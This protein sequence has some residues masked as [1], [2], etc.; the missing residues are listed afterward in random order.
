MAG[1]KIQQR[2]FDIIYRAIRAI[3]ILSVGI[4][5]LLSIAEFGTSYFI[6]IVVPSV[7]MLVFATRRPN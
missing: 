4:M 6:W 1:T 7:I 3:A 2:I 5:V